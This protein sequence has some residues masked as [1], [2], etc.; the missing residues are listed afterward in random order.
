MTH[1]AQQRALEAL[2][3]DDDVGTRKLVVQ[4]LCAEKEKNQELVEQLAHCSNPL[5]SVQARLILK[6][7]KGACGVDVSPEISPE[8]TAGWEQL[9][10]FCWLIAKTEY[11][12]FNPAYASRQLDQWAEAVQ[13]CYGE[14]CSRPENKL[15]ALQQILVDEQG[16]C[17]DSVTYYDPDNSYM[18]CVMESKQ[19]L[20]LTLALIYIFVGRRLQ[21]NVG[22]VN[23]PGH[24]LASVD[25]L[26]FDP[27]SGGK[28][29]G[30]A[31][32]AKR[33]CVNAEECQSPDFF[34]ATASETAHR[35]L[36]N[37]VNSYTRIGDDAK[38][39]RV[40][41]YLQILQ[42]NMGCG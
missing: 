2:L 17:G 35:M 38:L 42:D 32:L 36:S 9:E 7:W 21:W 1:I 34:Q 23:T 6:R 12:F 18:N 5:V 40:S 33:F 13:R 4:E 15:K 16:F 31:E 24:Y 3:A 20:P 10:Q 19:G 37:L 39:R 25:G 14:S 26:I 22:G 41:S 30:S 28:E 27:F 11:P 29:V 8:T